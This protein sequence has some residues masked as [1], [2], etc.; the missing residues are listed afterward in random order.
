M[1]MLERLFKRRR[2][3]P[4]A[5]ETFAML[6]GYTP[7]FTSWRGAIYESELARESIDAIARNFSKLRLTVQGTA[8]PALQAK[9]KAGPNPWQTYTQW[10][11]KTATILLTTN[12]AFILP[13]LDEWDEITGYYT[14]TP[15]TWELVEDEEGMIWI[16]FHFRDGRTGAMELYRTGILVRHQFKSDYF[17][18][19]NNAL[20]ETMQLIHLQNQGV[21]AGV[22]NA[23]SYKFMARL[24]SATPDPKDLVKERMRFSRMNFGRDSREDPLL[25]FPANYADIKQVQAQSVTVDPAQSKLIKDSIYSYFGT[26]DDIVQGKAYGDAYSAWY[27]TTLEPLAIQLSEVLT[28]MTFTQRERSFGAEIYLTTNR[29]QFMTSSQKQRYITENL[30]RGLITINEARD[31]LQ[32]PPLPDELGNVRPIRGEYYNADTGERLTSVEASLEELQEQ[33]RERNEGK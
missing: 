10:L 17:G 33:A 1:G 6:D 29:V 25:L 16:R 27:E 20:N 22:K 30:D 23:S 9:L 14:I 28:K 31:V 18:E 19:T 32:L 15:D 21:E 26:N 11:S 5:T 3:L 4:K 7:V 2:E 24:T 13:V 12:N 8:K